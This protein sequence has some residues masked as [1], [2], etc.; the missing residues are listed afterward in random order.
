MVWAVFILVTKVV[1]FRQMNYH[2]MLL[3]YHNIHVYR[4]KWQEASVMGN[5]LNIRSVDYKI[6][7]AG[8]PCV[9][10]ANDVMIVIKVVVVTIW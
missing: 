9:V 2:Q 8:Y 7:I 4:G 5:F 1:V 10:W 6:F 3:N